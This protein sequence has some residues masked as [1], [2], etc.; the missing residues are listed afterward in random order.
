MW[1][2]TAALLAPLIWEI[3]ATLAQES[4]DVALALVGEVPSADGGVFA[5]GGTGLLFAAS[6]ALAR[7][8]E[9]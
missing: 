1:I 4:P 5:T 9:Q 8:S 6:G 7:P 3:V 2:V